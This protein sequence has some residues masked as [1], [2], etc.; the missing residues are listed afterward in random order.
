MNIPPK[1]KDHTLKNG[2][3]FGP[4]Q[5]V[6]G[7]MFSTGMNIPPKTKDHTLK[8]GT[9]FGFF[10]RNVLRRRRRLCG[11]KGDYLLVMIS[12]QCACSAQWGVC[13]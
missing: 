13:I 5:L 1:T 8:N 11:L 6:F 9:V 4:W 10:L 3:V 12:N 7:S 2:T